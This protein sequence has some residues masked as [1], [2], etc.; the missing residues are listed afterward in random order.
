MTIQ[1]ADIEALLA[2]EPELSVRGLGPATA[3]DRADLLEMVYA[4]QVCEEFFAGVAKTDA[5]NRE[6]GSTAFLVLHA[7]KWANGVADGVKLCSGVLIGTALLIGLP[8]ERIGRGPEAW[9]ALDDVWVKRMIASVN[10][11]A[12]HN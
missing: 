6:A 1:R 9:L 4:F 10:A 11:M 5:P 7:Q 8:V 3:A 12:G 2:R